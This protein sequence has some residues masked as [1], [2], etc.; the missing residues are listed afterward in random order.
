M[1]KEIITC[2]DIGS[3]KV[4]CVI[5]QCGSFGIDIIGYG[6]KISEGIKNGSIA[7]INLAAQSIKSAVS[8]AELMSGIN[9]K[10]I[11][12]TVP[13]KYSSSHIEQINYKISS[14][15]IKH[16]DIRNLINKIRE[17]YKKNNQDL[18]H[19]IPLEYA[20]DN[21]TPV[22]SP[23][24]MFSSNLMAKFH[25]I[26]CSSST[27]K[28]IEYCF[29]Q[30]KLKVNNYFATAYSSIL[31]CLSEEEKKSCTLLID[32]GSNNTSISLVK[33]NK[34]IYIGG[35]NLAGN[36]ITRDI[37]IILDE[38]FEIAES[39]KI[40]NN[41]LIIRSQE[42]KELAKY[43][44]SAGV[45][46][47]ASINKKDL[48]KIITCRL[49]EIFTVSQK[50]LTEDGHNFSKIKNIVL[51][52]GCSMFIGVERMAENNFGIH[53]RIGYPTNV[54]RIPQQLNS[55]AFATV[56]GMI[57]AESKNIEKRR[58]NSSLISKVKNFFNL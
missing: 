5:A 47:T 4:S 55:P 21:N 38:K 29:E 53:T 20:I 13:N 26:C 28:N 54:P 48:G 32:I 57:L 19:L 11:A 42:K 10:T 44:T 24:G 56:I 43:K 49:E 40:S 45:N 36:N 15:S 41:S 12:T 7:D 23:I 22:I 18:I 9:I 6:Y 50:K 25:S 16:S 2:I 3:Y 8:D 17:D 33:E 14:G 31:S 51:T 1:N 34:V 46:N 27:L 37:S 35:H 58:E 52:G 39:I 30:S